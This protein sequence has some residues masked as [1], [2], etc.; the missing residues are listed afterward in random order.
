MGPQNRRAHHAAEMPSLL[1]IYTFS[2]E[3]HEAMSKAAMQEHFIGSIRGDVLFE[4][5]EGEAMKYGP[6]GK[7]Q[8]GG[9]KKDSRNVSASKVTEG[10][11]R[12]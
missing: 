3:T 1:G 2:E 11:G 12:R 4:G 9:W 5:A 7:A 6:V 8:W 10:L